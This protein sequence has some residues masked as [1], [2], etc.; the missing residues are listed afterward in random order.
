M[1]APWL[2]A[3]T[4][5]TGTVTFQAL[6]DFGNS[7]IGETMARVSIIADESRNRY[8]P[9]IE[10]T[11]ANG[12]VLQWAEGEGA[13][14]LTWASAVD[15]AGRFANEAGIPANALAALIDAVAAIEDSPSTTLLMD[16]VCDLAQAAST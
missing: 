5:H 7:R 15:S 1:S 16:R 11:F 9:A 2:A 13:Y 10:V 12:A 3:I 14:N 8:E 4:W 6:Q